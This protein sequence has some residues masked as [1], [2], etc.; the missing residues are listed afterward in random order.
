MYQRGTG[1]GTPIWLI[2]LVG[3]LVVFGGFFIWSGLLRFL[4]ASGDITAPVTA[5]AASAAQQDQASASASEPIPTIPTETPVRP[6][7]SFRVNVVKARVR[8]CAKDTCATLET[9]YSEGAVVCVYGVAPAATDWYE[10][11]LR[12]T[13]V[14]P[15]IVYMH[16]SVLDAI[17]PT[18]RPTRT[19]TALPTVTLIPTL[20][21]SR[22]P[23]F[24]PTDK[25]DKAASTPKPMKTAQTE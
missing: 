4:N 22:T 24:T 13:S 7:Q 21:P 16:T 8:E 18:R 15:Q 11:N 6:C 3:M 5:Q 2:V 14:Y 17:N 19:A 23:S 12:P 20:R 10:V 9:M 1:S 25:V